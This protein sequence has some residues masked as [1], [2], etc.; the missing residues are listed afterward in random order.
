VCVAL[1]GAVKSSDVHLLCNNLMEFVDVR[2]SLEGHK[3]SI[4]TMQPF[5]K[6]N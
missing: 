6:K 2:F 4:A 3:K 1:K 5:F